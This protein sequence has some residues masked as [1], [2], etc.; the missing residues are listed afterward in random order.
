MNTRARV[1]CICRK[2]ARSQHPEP[3]EGCDDEG[4]GH[5]ENYPH[6]STKLSM[7]DCN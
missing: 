2:N 5:V 4:T 1:L 6:A 7:L 3:V